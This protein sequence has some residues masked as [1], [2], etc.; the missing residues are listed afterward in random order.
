[1][2]GIRLE[3]LIKSYKKHGPRAV[4]Q[5]DLE[6]RDGE[7]MVLVGPSGCGKSTMMR[8]IAGIEEVTAGRILIGDRDVTHLDPRKRDVAMVFQN[9]ALYPHLSVR[10][11]LGF[12]LKLRGTGKG[13][14]AA[15]VAEV[16]Q[17]LG[18]EEVLDRR[19]GELSGG[20]RQRVAMGRAIVRE[21]AAFL[22]DEPL[23][24]LDAKLRVS[25]RAELSRLHERLGIT[26]VY[27]THD[28]V[29]AMTLGD[30][31]AVLRDGVLQQCATP[32]ELFRAPANLFVAGF[33]GSPAMNFARGSVT[34][35]GH[36]EFAGWR[37]PAHTGS[38][39]AAHAGREVILGIRPHDLALA[40]PGADAG[41][42]RVRATVEVVERLGTET[43]VIFPV[44]AS[45]AGDEGVLLAADSR[46]MFTAVVDPRASVAAGE[47][48]ELVLDPGRL[49]AFDPE[50]EHALSPDGSPSPNGADRQPS[51]ATAPLPAT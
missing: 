38:A 19:P 33:I 35:D 8:M 5:V 24:N 6:V 23:S 7:F 28:Q 41:L 3:G 42:P 1:M 22:M 44:Q 17:I 10:Q 15:R 16:A 27:V 29:E 46:A 40:T 26:T 32:D 49:H 39:L 12:G 47:T 36:V 34:A 18:L 30:R 13:D 31:V 14:I 48:V 9:Y 50:T 11:N 25:M 51:A 4:D 2:P 20:Q 37:V 21:P 45:R 43:H